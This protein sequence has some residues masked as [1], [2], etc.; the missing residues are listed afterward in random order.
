MSGMPIQEC[1]FCGCGRSVPQR[2][3]WRRSANEQGRAMTA[4][5]VVS[6]R[7]E[8]IIE[9]LAAAVHGDMDAQT[10]GDDLRAW[11]RLSTARFAPTNSSKPL[12]PA[13]EGSDG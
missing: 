9:A 13:D 1:C 10:L 5:A 12:V 3:L 2:S 8:R 7:D 6:A 11:Q 4:G